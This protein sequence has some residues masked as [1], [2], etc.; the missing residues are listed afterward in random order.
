MGVGSVTVQGIADRVVTSSPT[1]DYSTI[2]GLTYETYEAAPLGGTDAYF[3][4]NAQSGAG[5][6]SSDDK[7]IVSYKLSVNRPVERDFVLRG[8]NTKYTK[9]PKQNGPTVA[10]FELNLP[11][12]DTSAVDVFS[13]WSLGTL[14]KA[15][16]FFNGTQI[17]SGTKRSYEYQLPSIKAVEWPTGADAPNNNSRMRPK[18]TFDILQASAAP[19]GMSVTDY[20]LLTEVCTRVA[21][22]C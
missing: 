8:A 13:L 11:Y 20:C 14:Q 1:N 18:L 19:T 9:E 15:E 21:A 3:R 22:Y 6:S 4:M 5:L 2:N 12:F 17:G 10:T 16:L 7:E